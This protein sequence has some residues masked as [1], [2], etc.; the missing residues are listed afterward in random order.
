MRRVIIE[1]PFAGPTPEIRKRNLAY[2]FACLR[3]SLDLGEAPFAS[4]LLYPQVLEDAVVEQRA[5]GMKAGWTW[6]HVA[7][8]VIAYTDLGLSDGMKG[9][10]QV[11]HQNRIPVEYR[12]LGWTK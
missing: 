6:L 3:H 7:E 10:L 5:Q 4:H 9:G 2:A 12:S 1:S 11:A 8:A